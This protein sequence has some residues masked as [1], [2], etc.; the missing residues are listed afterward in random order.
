MKTP[1]RWTSLGV[2]SVMAAT[3]AHLRPGMGL[4]PGGERPDLEPVVEAL[5]L[6]LYAAVAA[7]SRAGLDVVVDIGHHDAHSRPL[8]LL[9]RCAAIIAGLPALLVGVRCPMDV[10]LERRRITWGPEAADEGRAH[11]WAEAVHSPGIYDLEL[12]TSQATPEACAEAIRRRLDD[13]PPP[14]AF[15]RLAAMA[16]E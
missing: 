5:T 1:G 10:I 7:L 3:P 2:D 11:P 13:G 8:K 4:R 15:A 6:G 9:P 16:G 12:D 14:T